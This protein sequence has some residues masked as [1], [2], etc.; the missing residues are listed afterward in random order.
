[1]NA[2]LIDFRVTR[3]WIGG[4]SKTE[5]RTCVC[6]H[7]EH[8]ASSQFGSSALFSFMSSLHRIRS[9]FCLKFNLFLLP[10]RSL[11]RSPPLVLQ[12][13]RERKNPFLSDW[14]HGNQKCENALS[15]LSFLVLF[16]LSAISV[17]WQINDTNFS[18]TF[19]LAYIDGI[20]C[21]RARVCVLHSLDLFSCSI[22]CCKLYDWISSFWQNGKRNYMYALELKFSLNSTVLFW[23]CHHVD[24]A[25]CRAIILCMKVMGKFTSFMMNCRQHLLCL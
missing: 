25:L 7:C 8:I 2:T 6:A 17:L 4:C 9:K 11:R 13:E 20:A 22:I 5:I 19:Y 23:R 12:N 21:M 3:G 15:L 10:I 1:M 24:R 14:F 16:S 18:Y